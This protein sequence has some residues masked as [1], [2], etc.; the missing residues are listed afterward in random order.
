[1]GARCAPTPATCQPAP[2]PPADRV[3][4]TTAAKPAGAKRR[5]PTDP[6]LGVRSLLVHVGFATTVAAIA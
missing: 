5:R 6:Q 2:G 1:M 4:Q 3:A